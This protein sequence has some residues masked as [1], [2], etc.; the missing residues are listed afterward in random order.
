MYSTE[1]FEQVLVLCDSAC[2][3]SAVSKKLGKRIKLH[4][5]PTELTVRG[6]KAQKTIHTPIVEINLTPVHFVDCRASFS[7]ESYVK[8]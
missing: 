6:N 4:G 5:H 1:C 2:S 7:I 3:L 8:K